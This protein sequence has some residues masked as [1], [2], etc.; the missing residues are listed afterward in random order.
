MT[1]KPRHIRI[2]KNR[3]RK[4]THYTAII[5]GIL[6]A[7]YLYISFIFGQIDKELKGLEK[8]VGKI[9]VFLPF[10]GI[11]YDYIEPKIIKTREGV[12]P[13]IL[14]AKRLPA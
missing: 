1:I 2:F 10:K 13:V 9:E 14:Y 5:I 12:D 7:L 6:V 11:D 4:G 3:M 8:R